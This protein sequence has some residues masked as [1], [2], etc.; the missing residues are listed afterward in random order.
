MNDIANIRYIVFMINPG[1][2]YL[3]GRLT[4]IHD[5]AIF[6]TLKEAKEYA[7]DSIEGKLATRFVIGFFVWDARDE[8]MNIICIEKFGF[9]GDR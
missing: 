4:D 1:M 6:R 3:N 5:G 9:K 7:Q 2:Q 8:M